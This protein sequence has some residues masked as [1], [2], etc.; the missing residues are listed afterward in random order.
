MKAL[1]LHR[2]RVAPLLRRDIDTDQIIP[3][4]FLKSIDRSGFGR[5]LFNDWRFGPGGEPKS[6]FVL[7]DE[8][9][10]GATILVTGPNFGCG[11]SREHAAWALEDYG[12][13][14]V[15][16]PSFADIFRNNAITNGVL[17]VVLPDS[18]V[19]DIA[20]RA[21][22]AAPY[23][24]E[25]DLESRRVRDETGLEGSFDIDDASRHRLLK[26]LDDIGLIL[27]HARAIDRY[28]SQLVAPA[29][30]RAHHAE[31]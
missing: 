19:N 25:V 15:I 11:S 29:K 22:A 2:G 31:C 28:E 12:F 14:V 3:K 30:A 20:A 1:R 18:I 24:M 8:R 5:Y 9:Y 7:N 6:D 16:S 17:P 10:R 21:A 23:E 13:R 4:Q 27:E 26:G